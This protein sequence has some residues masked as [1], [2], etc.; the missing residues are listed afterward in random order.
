LSTEFL[1]DDRLSCD[2]LSVPRRDGA[3]VAEPWGTWRMWANNFHLFDGTPSKI[4]IDHAMNWGLGVSEP[5]LFANAN[6]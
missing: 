6:A 1:H 5:L 3:V 4:W 2:E